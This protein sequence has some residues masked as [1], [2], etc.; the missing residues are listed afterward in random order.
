M[1][2]APVVESD[3][4]PVRLHGRDV[5]WF[6]ALERNRA[7]KRVP[8]KVALAR[9]NHRQTQRLVE[10]PTRF[11]ALET[12]AE[13]VR[14]I[15]VRAD[16]WQQLVAICRQVEAHRHHEKVLNGFIHCHLARVVRWELKLILGKLAHAHLTVAA[17]R[18][19]REMLP[20]AKGDDI[21]LAGWGG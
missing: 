18:S 8:A 20:L 4:D 19:Q 7:F 3:P 16:R 17:K 5:K 1:Q 21:L 6:G 12:H 11:A 13:H 2:K 9:L 10:G 15:I 14:L